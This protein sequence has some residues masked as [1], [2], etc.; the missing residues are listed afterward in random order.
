VGAGP[1]R[2]Q[3]TKLGFTRDDVTGVD[4]RL[5]NEGESLNDLE[6]RTF[7]DFGGK[8]NLPFNSNN[9]PMYKNYDPKC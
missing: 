1:G 8:A 7:N 4:Y 2:A 9:P 3:L 6:S 5:P